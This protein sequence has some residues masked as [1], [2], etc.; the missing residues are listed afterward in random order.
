MKI[1]ECVPNI[2]EGKDKDIIQKITASLK[3]VAVL[4]A[5]SDA[6]ANR[7]VI[8]FAGSPEAVENA[9]FQLIKK[10]HEL[11]DM[12]TQKGVHPRL[13]AVDV[14]PF[15][16]VKN[17]T[18]DECVA[19]SK[20]VARRVADELNLSVYL[21]ENSS[22]TEERK[23]L[24][25]IRKGEYESL[26]QKLKAL[27]PDF[28]PSQF[29]PKFGAVIMGARNFLIAYN[30]N[31]KTK[32]VNTAQK[33]AREI[34][35]ENLKA[36]GWYLERFDIVQVSCNIT[37]YTKMPLRRVYD[38]IDEK[39]K[40]AGSQLI[41]LIPSAAINH[42]DVDYLGLNSLEPF[43]WDEKVLEQRLLKFAKSIN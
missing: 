28:G 35:G 38:M 24:A 40:A 23:K 7:T 9:A 3:G 34:R 30:V 41:G 37:D 13:G 5:E 20:R 43:V 33:I 26:P 21:Y 36:I 25:F 6:D 31:L 8:T 16:P 18:M 42:E 32:D 19:L 2:S 14:C 22:S 4:G 1:I 17:V 11:L 15:V 29:N 39:S 12:S 27:P 10:S